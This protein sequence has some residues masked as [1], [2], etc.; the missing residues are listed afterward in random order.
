MLKSSI[1]ILEIHW[2]KWSIEWMQIHKIVSICVHL[3]QA[4]EQTNK[5]GCWGARCQQIWLEASLFS[6]HFL[7]LDS[8]GIGVIGIV[9][10]RQAGNNQYLLTPKRL[11]K[12]T[13]SDSRND[14]LLQRDSN[15]QSNCNVTVI[16]EASKLQTTS[17]IENGSALFHK[18]QS[19]MTGLC[20]C[21]IAGLHF[22]LQVSLFDA[23]IC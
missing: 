8:P 9:W 22:N 6:I 12:S 2:I 18:W 5:C 15:A 3:Q 23:G 1:W 19:V 17:Q 16:N 11:N 7:L 21:S 14:M 10:I 20:N 4:G 13:I